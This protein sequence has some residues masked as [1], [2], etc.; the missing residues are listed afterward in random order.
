VFSPEEGRP[1]AAIFKVKVIVFVGPACN[2]DIQ[3]ITKLGPIQKSNTHRATKGNGLVQ[4]TRSLVIIV[5]PPIWRL[6][7]RHGVSVIDN[8][9]QSV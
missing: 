3:V 4:R 8:P 7:A 1:V 2:L 6:R 9:E 5:Y